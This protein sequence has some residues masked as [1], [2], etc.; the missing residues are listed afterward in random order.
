MSIPWKHNRF[1]QKEQKTGGVSLGIL[2][3]VGS[4]T[5]TQTKHKFETDL[6]FHKTNSQLIYIHYTC[7]GTKN[8]EKRQR[9]NSTWHS[10]LEDKIERHQ[11]R[12]EEAP[13]GSSPVDP[14][15][16]LTARSNEMH[17]KAQHVFFKTS[18]V[19][20]VCPSIRPSLGSLSAAHELK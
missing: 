8:G 11:Q 1:L 3:D 6:K 13:K 20:E 9:R 15:L 17:R 12:G 14:W 16:L 5:K 10:V 4:N 2:K 18:D 7:S 19:V